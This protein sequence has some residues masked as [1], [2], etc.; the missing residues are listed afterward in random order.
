MKLVSLKVNGIADT[1]VLCFRFP[2]L[3][4]WKR[5]CGGWLWGMAVKLS[6][7]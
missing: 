3:Q 2:R 7:C 5:V 1:E 4:G 6:D